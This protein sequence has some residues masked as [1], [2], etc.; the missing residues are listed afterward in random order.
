MTAED[1]Y[2][3]MNQ[4]KFTNMAQQQRLMRP[5]ECFEPGYDTIAFKQDQ[6]MI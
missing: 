6:N 2:I 1:K 5:A 3:S 4:Y